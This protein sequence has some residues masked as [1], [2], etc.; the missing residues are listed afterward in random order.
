M[1]KFQNYYFSKMFLS[2]ASESCFF[3]SV[4]GAKSEKKLHL[5]VKQI[6]SKFIVYALKTLQMQMLLLT[7]QK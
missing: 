7:L 4:C 1:L 5:T 6:C 2:S 3:T